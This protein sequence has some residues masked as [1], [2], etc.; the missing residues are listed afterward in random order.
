MKEIT[1]ND[2]KELATVHDLH[3]LS[4]FIPTHVSGDKDIL[5][6]DALLL[7]KELK[8]IKRK[9]PA[10]GLAPAEIEE[11]VSPIQE[12]ADDPEFWSR[13]EGGLAL[14]LADDLFK[15]YVLSEKFAPYHYV[16]NEFYIIPLFPAVATD[17]DFY[18]LT[19]ELD[20]VKLFKSNREGFREIDITETVPAGMKEVV[21]SDYEEKSLQFKSQ[22]QGH[23]N[24]VF[25]GHGEG[26]DKKT[27]INKYLRAVDKGLAKL[28]KNEKVPVVMAG[29]DY[30]CAMYRE[31][32]SLDNLNDHHI[33]GSPKLMGLQSLHKSAL[34]LLQ[35]Y[36]NKTKKEKAEA[37]RQLQGTPKTANSVDY[38]VPAAMSGKIDTLFILK[39]ED[40]FGMYDEVSDKV[41]YKEGAELAEVSLFNLAAKEA[42]LHGANVYVVDKDEMP[43]GFSHINALYR[44]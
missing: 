29:A 26:D 1:E 10:R 38:I 15:R 32:T 35:P 33:S 6:G 21:G 8:E 18:L 16:S 44:F 2:L 4:V 39:N 20:E 41:E 5:A 13:Q 30:L 36:F 40:V 34:N 19:L 12:L 37:F 43:D 42:F 25:Y 23:G 17:K 9:L 27:E 7:K 28:L 3:C 31:L 24:S 22:Q 14:F 11:W